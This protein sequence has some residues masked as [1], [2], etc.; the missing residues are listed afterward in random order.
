M[1][2]YDRQE[3]FNDG[4]TILAEHGNNE[5][6]QVE[7][8]MA[9][10][11]GHTHNGSATEGAPVPL[12]SDVA[13]TDKVEIVAGGAKTTG[14]HQ[15]TGVLTLDAGAAITGSV[16]VTGTVDGRDVSVDGAKLDLLTPATSSGITTAALLP[17]SAFSTIAATNTQAALQ[18]IQAE[19]PTTA[20]ELTSVAFSTIA[21]TETQAALQEIQ[22]EI[23]TTASELTSVAF[24]TIAAVEVQAALQEIQ[25]EIPIT[26]SELTFVPAGTISSTDVQA[27]IEEVSGD[28]VLST[29]DFQEFLT[30]GT[31]TKPA[32]AISVYVEVIGGGGGGFNDT[33]SNSPASAGG[34]GGWNNGTFQDSDLGATE[35][36]TIGAGGTGGATGADND[37]SPGG[38]TTFGASLVKGF[39]GGFGVSTAV[40]NTNP[41]LLP[42]GGVGI[43]SFTVGSGGTNN[44]LTGGNSTKGGAGGGGVDNSPFVGRPGGVSEEAG[45][46]A[47]GNADSGVAAGN[48]TAPGGGG[49]ASAFN[50]GAGSG[51]AGRVRVWTTVA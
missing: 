21:A 35:T 1:A 20:S 34:G 27:A 50:G 44:T 10:S 12:I 3:V 40:T 17:S 41:L 49:G 29:I 33:A 13:G 51:A 19:I 7:A 43:S 46:G 2:G 36:I 11:G 23:P 42:A 30:S 26:A 45:D 32:N 38:D 9:A 15:V 48:G 22:G 39:G 18:E 47:A 25:A 28:I 4:D 14:T 37:G 16:T 24:S 31:W 6:N 8:A 5:F